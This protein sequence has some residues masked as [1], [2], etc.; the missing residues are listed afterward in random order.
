ML[1]ANPGNGNLSGTTSVSA[2]GGIASFGNLS[3][4]KAGMGY[5]LAALDGVLGSD[6]QLIAPV[7]IGEG[8]YVAAGSTITG[9]VPPGALAVA[10]AKQRNIEGYAERQQPSEQQERRLH[11]EE[12]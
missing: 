7:T 9:D 3:I 8:A 4:D 2:V 1:A 10:R 5:T 11:S 12:R 6:S